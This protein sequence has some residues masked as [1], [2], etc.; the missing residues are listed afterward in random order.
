MSEHKQ[1]CPWHQDWHSCNCGAFD[2]PN[3][4]KEI[5]L[6]VHHRSDCVEYYEGGLPCPD[7]IPAGCA[8]Q[9]PNTFIMC[10]EMG[11]YCSQECMERANK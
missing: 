9:I 3:P 5:K 6:G 2:M 8:G 7:C 4:C 1:E 10:G 11:Q